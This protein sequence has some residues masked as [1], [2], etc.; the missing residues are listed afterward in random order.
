MLRENDAAYMSKRV[1][2]VVPA[3]S[4]QDF[5]KAAKDYAAYRK[6]FPRSFF[7]RHLQEGIG[8]PGQRIL[9]LGTGTG[10]LARGFAKRGA[11]VT[12][13]DISPQLI[14]QA[15]KIGERE[16]VRVAYI[17]GR[18]ESVPL[19]S[20][21]FDVVTAGQCW[22]WFDGVAA[23]GESF[24][25]LK[26]GG[27]LL[28]AYFTYLTAGG[29]VAARTEALILEHNPAWP[30]SGSNGRYEKWKAH[31]QPAGFRDIRCRDYDEDILYTHEEWRGRIRACSGALALSDPAKMRSLDRQLARLLKREFP[32][33][34]LRIPHRVFAIQGRKP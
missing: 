14:G 32:S 6:G 22:H 24:R 29:N 11:Q 19:K 28:I 18:A 26:S 13:L 12:G 27:L 15:R 2:T 33:E 25:L 4:P 10:T 8:K 1:E 30:F 5:G 16:G 21:R 3:F 23:A 9:D 20:A 7:D 31:M 17:L 34:P